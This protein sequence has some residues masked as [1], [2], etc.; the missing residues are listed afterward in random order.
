MIEGWQLAIV[1][2]PF[3]LLLMFL[4][5]AVIAWWLRRALPDGALKRFLFISWKV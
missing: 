3:G 1:L 2:K 5:G 4:P